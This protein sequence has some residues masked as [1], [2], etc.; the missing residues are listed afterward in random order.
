MSGI[1]GLN[2]RNEL[3]R[4]AIKYLFDISDFLLGWLN[5]F[6]IKSQS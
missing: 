6:G 5:A 3:I 1:D 4:P 2:E